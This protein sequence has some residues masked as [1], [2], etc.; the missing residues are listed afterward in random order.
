MTWGSISTGGEFERLA[1]YSRALFDDEWVFVSGTT[2]QRYPGT[3]ID[4]DVVEQTRQT[5]RTI[6]AV[7]AR[8]GSCLAE[9]VRYLV[10]VTDRSYVRPVGEV[11][12][13]FFTQRPAPAGTMLI[14]QLVAPEMKVEIEVVARRPSA[15]ALGTSK[16]GP[17]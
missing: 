3:D 17:S 15:A 16:Q 13:E 12:G 6:D 2:G 11:F 5:L 9:V 4:E 10:V 14:A 8:A 7:L 1:P